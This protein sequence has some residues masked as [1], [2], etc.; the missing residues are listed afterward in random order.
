[1][2]VIYSHILPLP[3]TPIKKKKK[4]NG[5]EWK[6]KYPSVEKKRGVLLPQANEFPPNSS[7]S[8]PNDDVDYGDEEAVAPPFG[9]GNVVGSVEHRC[10]SDPVVRETTHEVRE[11]RQNHG[12][13]I[14]RSSE[15]AC[16]GQE[17]REHGSD[18]GRP[19]GK[20]VVRVEVE[21]NQDPERVLPRQT[22]PTNK[23]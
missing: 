7:D 8:E 20:E 5:R 10:R 6:N 3:N 9:E 13:E 22:Q 4:K 21:Q 19:A 15:S 2:S 16:H 14:R 1:M 18:V 11:E 17:G 12:R 23:L